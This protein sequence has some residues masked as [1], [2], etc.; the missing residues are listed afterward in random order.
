MVSKAMVD[1]VKI[2]TGKNAALENWQVWGKTGTANIANANGTYDE[3]N[4][5]ASFIGGA[6]VDNPAVV[7]TV[8]IRKPN[9]SLHKGY[10]GGAVA[11]PVAAEIL[12]KTLTYLKIDKEKVEK[13]KKEE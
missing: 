12:D 4:Y 2:G 3:Q 11:A 9:K 10:A 7:V 1:V 5:V 8:S 13:A 6:P